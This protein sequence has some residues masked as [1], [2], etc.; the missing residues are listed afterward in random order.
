MSKYVEKNKGSFLKRISLKGRLSIVLGAVSFVL[1]LVLCYI[2]VHSFELDIDP[3]IDDSMTE[4]AMNGAAE[5]SS[6]VDKLSHISAT[7]NEGISFIYDENDKVGEAPVQTW[8]VQ[9]FSKNN[10]VSVT[11]MDPVTLRS[12]IVDKEIPA[13]RYNAEAVLLNT[14]HAS[15]LEDENII[16]GGTFFEP[17]TF[18]PDSS[19]YGIFITREGAK[20]KIVQRIDYDL[21]KDKEYY[22]A[23]KEGKSVITN[24][25]KDDKAGGAEL[26]TITSPIMVNGEFKGLTLLDINADVLTKVSKTDAE[27]PTMF[28]EIIDSEEVIHGNEKQRGMKLSDVLS[29][30][31]YKEVKDLMAG[32]ERFTRKVIG[33]SGA[34]EREFF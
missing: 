21:Y 25:Y 31:A 24:V 15:I 11:G 6:T 12:G 10:M 9:D 14:L 2:L 8:K 33:K 19:D 16:G 23:G 28:S 29:E 3:Q 4:K 13:S 26:F 7:I 18:F 1:I 32:G 5:L 22:K 34:A 27:Y 17:N 30:K 20:E